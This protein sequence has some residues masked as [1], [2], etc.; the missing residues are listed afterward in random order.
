MRYGIC[1]WVFGPEPLA[2]TLERLARLG[3]DEVELSAEPGLYDPRE[4][5]RLVADFGLSVL[6][7]TSSA[8]WPTETRDLGNPESHGRPRAVDYFGSCVDMA[9]ELN[10]AYAGV[11]PAPS[12]RF[13]GLSSYADEWAWVVEGVRE[14][15]QYAASVGAPIAV[16]VL[17]RYEAFLVNTAAQGLHLLDEVDCDSVRLILDVFHLHPEERDLHAALRQTK[18]DLV[19]LHLADTNRQGLGRRHLD[20]PALLGTLREIEYQGPVC[21]ECSALGPNP[22]M[23]IKDGNSPAELEAF[24]RESIAL[25]RAWD[26]PQP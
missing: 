19:A 5:N 26:P 22:F 25:L 13:F 7:L 9:A 4:I 1:N 21:L 18:G 8:D 14:V 20:L 10:A 17:N 15:G 6:G 11:L 3:Y 23:M 12:G 16:E 24:S 2:K